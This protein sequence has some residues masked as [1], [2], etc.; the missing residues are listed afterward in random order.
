[1]YTIAKDIADTRAIAS[2]WNMVGDLEDDECKTFVSKDEQVVRQKFE[3]GRLILC[4]SCHLST[5]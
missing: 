3:A 2:L 5:D 1:M 4:G